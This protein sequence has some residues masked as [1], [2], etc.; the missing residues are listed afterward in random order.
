[1]AE[2]EIKFELDT[3]SDRS[4]GVLKVNDY[5]STLELA[6][7]ILD[8]HPVFE[9][10]TDADKKE[11][12]ALRA[13]Y[14]KIVKEIDRRRIDTIADFTTEF[15]EQCNSIKELFDN[16]Q[17]ELGQRI[18]AYEEEHKAAVVEGDKVTKYTATLKFTDP[19]LVDKLTQFA[20]KYGCELVIK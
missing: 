8:V 9:I 17:K 4:T 7:H 18:L 10:L 6:K 1:M 11:A 15:R 5:E 20:Q 16:A 2:E 3:V 13:T 12:K 14:N 19:K